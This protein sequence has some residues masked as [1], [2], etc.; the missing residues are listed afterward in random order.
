MCYQLPPYSKQEWQSS[1]FDMDDRKDLY[2]NAYVQQTADYMSSLSTAVKELEFFLA[3]K[4]VLL[5][6]PFIIMIRCT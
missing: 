2:A 6:A 1:K 4:E 3:S 5:V